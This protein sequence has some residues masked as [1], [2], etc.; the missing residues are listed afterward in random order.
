MDFFYGTIGLLIRSAHSLAVGMNNAT[1]E[2]EIQSA[3]FIFA[4][5][6][7]DQVKCKSVPDY[8]MGAEKVNLLYH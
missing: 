1:S 2:R 5:F 4:Y 3:S 7:L 6:Q 8:T